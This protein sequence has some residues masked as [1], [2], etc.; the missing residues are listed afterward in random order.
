M[1]R[2]PGVVAQTRSLPCRR[3]WAHAP[4]GS[5][6]PPRT[7]SAPRL[8]AAHRVDGRTAAAPLVSARR[9]TGPHRSRTRPPPLTASDKQVRRTASHAGGTAW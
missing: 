1:S 4:S 8:S 9:L 5:S 2:R 3:S 6:L 7:R